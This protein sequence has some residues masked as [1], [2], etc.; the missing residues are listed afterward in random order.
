[1]LVKSDRAAS[2]RKKNRLSG[3]ERQSQILDKAEKLCA[4]K[5]FAGTT[6][7]DIAREVGISRALIIQHFGNKEGI[8]EALIDH[9]FQHHPLENDPDLQELIEKRD[10]YGVFKAFSSHIHKFVTKDKTYSPLRLIF[11]SML[12]K[13]NL[14]EKHCQKKRTRALK[15]LE[16]YIALRIEEG[17]FKNVPPRSLATGFMAMLAYLFFQQV[18]VPHLYDETPLE[19]Y[20][21]TMIHVLMDGLKRENPRF[22]REPQAPAGDD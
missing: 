12:E 6:L 3:T 1:M 17:K 21:D 5:G 13:P 8:Y 16:D 9:L 15:V 18:T 10:D 19:A 2:T 14:Y 4:R 22:S 7:D 11:Y 20:V